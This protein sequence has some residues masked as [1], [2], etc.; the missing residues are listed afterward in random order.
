[1]IGMPSTPRPPQQRANENARYRAREAGAGI[2]RMSVTAPIDRIPH[3]RAITLEWRRDAKMLLESDLPTSD[4]ILQVHAV[5]RTL[6]LK[7]PIEV[8]ETRALAEQWLLAHQ[9]Q[10]GWR[11]LHKPRHPGRRR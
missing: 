9:P 8:F 10:T 2:V 4:Q 5:C 11:I 3:L 6:F 1:V 7:L